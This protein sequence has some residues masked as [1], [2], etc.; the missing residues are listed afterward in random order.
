MRRRRDEPDFASFEAELRAVYDEADALYA[1]WSCPASTECCRFGITGRE[2]YV[3]SVELAVVR[4][5]VARSGRALDASSTR[6]KRKLPVADDARG[7]DE[8][9]CPLLTSEGRCSIYADRPFGCRTYFCDRATEGSRVKH[10]EVTDLVRRLKDLS[11]RHEP[12]GDVGRPLVRA[13][14]GRTNPTG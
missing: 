12:E 4:R 13:L 2:P 1:G 9:R 5:A 14:G 8:R 11:A 3:T 10:R 6:D 7:R